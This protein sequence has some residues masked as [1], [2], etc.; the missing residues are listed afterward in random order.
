MTERPPTHTGEEAA[1]CWVCGPEN[2]QGLQIPLTV[3]GDVIRSTFTPQP[4]HQ[5]YDGITH[6][7]LIG[8][9]LDDIM[10]NCFYRRGETAYTAKM[11]I[12]F[13]RFCPTGK[14]L[15]IEARIVERR[16][17]R[18][19]AEATARLDD[20]TLVAEASGTYSVR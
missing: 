2:A 9:V 14:P 8:A 17:R 20:G 15:H 18:A 12:R 5:G 11:E 6:G 13:K 16:G 7:G 19:T 1:R 3:D 10:A 4:H